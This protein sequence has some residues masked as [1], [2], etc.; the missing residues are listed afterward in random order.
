[1]KNTQDL[2]KFSKLN[3]PIAINIKHIKHL[4]SVAEHNEIK[5]GRNHS[6]ENGLQ[7]SLN[8]KMWIETH[9]SCKGNYKK[10]V[11]TLLQRTSRTFKT[12]GL[13]SI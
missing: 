9:F 6:Q 11:I 7:I 4:Q 10:K 13:V 3:M 8:T 1:M 12:G 5:V 2:K